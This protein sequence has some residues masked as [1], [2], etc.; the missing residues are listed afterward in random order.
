MLFYS[1]IST[2][3]TNKKPIIAFSPLANYSAEWNKPVYAKC[4]TASKAVYMSK[5][6]RD[7]IYILNLVRT[8]PK[9]FAN[10]V[11]KNYPDKTGSGWLPYSS[12]YKSLMDTLLKIEPTNLL[13]PDKLCFTS[14]EC[15]ATTS[16]SKGYV[17]HDRQT[18]ECKKK[19]HFYG[20]CCDYGRSTALDIVLGLLIDEDVPS[21]VH[22]WICLGYYKKL[23]V[24]IQ[25]HTSFGHNA[26]LDFSY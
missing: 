3:Q 17:G 15:H 12:Y 9:Q 11:L 8:Y 13:T 1:L 24:S 4:N 7:V 21:L 25:P 2:S 18:D 19:E 14:A 10:T 23:G 20:E 26:V 22:R 16:G 5:M 6:E